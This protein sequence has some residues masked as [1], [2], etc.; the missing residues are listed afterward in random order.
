[1]F[2]YNTSG[3][4]FVKNPRDIYCTHVWYTVLPLVSW[5]YVGEISVLGHFNEKAPKAMKQ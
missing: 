2:L 1:M 5:S 3:G 4:S